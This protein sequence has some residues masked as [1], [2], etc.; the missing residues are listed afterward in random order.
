MASLNAAAECGCNP[1][2]SAASSATQKSKAPKTSRH[3]AF[4]GTR[5]DSFLDQDDFQHMGPSSLEELFYSPVRFL[6]RLQEED[7]GAPRRLVKNFG[8]LSF[9]S[10]YSGCNADYVALT[11]VRD[12]LKELGMPA[13]D[14][15][16]LHAC[17]I[18]KGP[19][20]LLSS[21]SPPPKHIFMD[22]HDRLPRNVLKVEEILPAA[23]AAVDQ[24][25]FEEAAK[26][27][28]EIDGKRKQ[29]HQGLD[30]S[31]KLMG[32]CV[33]HNRKCPAREPPPPEKWLTLSSS[34]V[35]CK[36]WSPFGKKLGCAGPS[37]RELS[38]WRR[39]SLFLL[40]P[41]LVVECST[42]LPLEVAKEGLDDAYAWTELVLQP[43]WF[44]CPISR[45]RKFF[46]G[47]L[48]GKVSLAKELSTQA[49]VTCFGRSSTFRR[50][51]R[52]LAWQSRTLRPESHQ[53]WELSHANVGMLKPV[54]QPS[55]S[56]VDAG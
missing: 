23:K 41:I 8:C 38:H 5:A 13:P 6:E 30:R 54:L 39:E 37:S 47:L 15:L 20:Q 18:A 43:T 40:H 50:L 55:T 2:R 9:Y 24:R 17:D 31:A 53:N 4:A 16:H 19:L 3:G 28:A 46:V 29:F 22:M 12:G 36:D 56:K 14:V 35:I 11:H 52:G 1:K 32:H 27:Y 42:G 25:Q 26:K 10:H 48:R 49:V 34:G 7:S 51:Q 44:G 21:M 33:L 45:E